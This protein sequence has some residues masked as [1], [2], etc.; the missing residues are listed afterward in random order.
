[1][2]VSALFTQDLSAFHVSVIVDEYRATFVSA[3]NAYNAD[4]SAANWDQV[5]KAAIDGW[6]YQYTQVNG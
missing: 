5:V 1:M 4:Q 3:L 6:A 2:K